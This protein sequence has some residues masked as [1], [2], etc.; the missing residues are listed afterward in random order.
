ME[1]TALIEKIDDMIRKAMSVEPP[2]MPADRLNEIKTGSE[3]DLSANGGEDVIKNKEKSE[4]DIEDAEKA[5]DAKPDGLEDLKKEAP[6]ADDKDE[7]KEDKKEDPKEDD[8][9]EDEDD[10]DEAPKKDKKKKKSPP[11]DDKDDKKSD[12]PFKKSIEVTPEQY[13]RLQKALKDDADKAAAEVAEKVAADAAAKEESFKKSLGDVTDLIKKLSNDLEDLK[14]QPVRL[15]KSVTGYVPVE[16]GEPEKA[17]LK[18][19]QVLE[20]MEGLQ[21]DGKIKDV[22]VIEYEVSGTIQDPEVRALVKQTIN[23][24]SQ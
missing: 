7:K 23:S 20:V 5:K 1:D 3:L 16:K 8:G 13:D 6:K 24:K 22:H 12:L 11:K 2:A 15:A 17:Q 10:E 4:A 9:D 19:S 14:K 21:R 18:K